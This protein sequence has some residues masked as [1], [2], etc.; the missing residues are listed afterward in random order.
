[1]S[2][3]LELR[4]VFDTN[5]L[6]S[7]LL[8][9]NSIPAQALTWAGEHGAILTSLDLLN[10]LRTV[11]SRP[12][13]D[14]YLPR[15]E[16]DLFLAALIRDSALVDVVERIV[17]C[18]DPKDDHVLELAVNGQATCVVSGDNDLLTLHPFRDIPILKP[19][20]FLLQYGHNS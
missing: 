18:R 15:D 17:V 8:M 4:F 1:M 13:F 12:K 2:Q 11:L 20:E 14:R 10:E 16:R 5:A 3:P 6:V 7:G 19:A 9:P